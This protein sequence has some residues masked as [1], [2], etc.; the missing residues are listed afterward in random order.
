MKREV[1]GAGYSSPCQ[2]QSSGCQSDA[3]QAK[4][5]V[6]GRT[7]KGAGRFRY[8]SAGV[9]LTLSKQQSALIGC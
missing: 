3:V 1:A 6:V 4:K 8:V 2:G 7:D 9:K 5:L